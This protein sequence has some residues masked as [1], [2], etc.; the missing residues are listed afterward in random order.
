[1]G[2]R[3]GHR[4]SLPA[5]SQ[6]DKVEMHMKVTLTFSRE[7]F[8]ISLSL[9]LFL[10]LSVELSNCLYGLLNFFSC[11]EQKKLLEIPINSDR[12]LEGGLTSPLDDT[13]GSCLRNIPCQLLGTKMTLRVKYTLGHD[14][15]QD[16]SLIQAIRLPGRP[17]KSTGSE[18]K[19]H[20]SFHR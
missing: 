15:V 13:K 8:E 3:Q 5:C 9:W 20:V 2:D 12:S 17:P 7:M 14:Q 10:W 16:L 6:W 11:G 4:V 18:L 1:M 19:R